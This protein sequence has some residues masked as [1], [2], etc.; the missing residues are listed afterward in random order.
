MS[1]PFKNRIN[2][3]VLSFTVNTS[4]L[5]FAAISAS[6]SSI[7]VFIEIDPTTES[8]LPATYSVALYKEDVVTTTQ[9][10]TTARPLVEGAEL[11]KN[12]AF[13]GGDNWIEY[14]A[15]YT[16]NT[17]GSVSVSVP[18]YTSGENWS[19]QTTTIILEYT[20]TTD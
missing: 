4:I 14:G 9:A 5:A 7:P 3:T 19:T 6:D 16:N 15:D 18:A 2:S 17:N 8:L 10:P 13:A 12:T 20:K 1:S 11:L